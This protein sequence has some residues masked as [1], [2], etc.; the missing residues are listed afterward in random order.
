MNNLNISKTAIYYFFRNIA[1][2]MV[3]LSDE[4]FDKSY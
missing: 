2:G 1:V 3:I 4:D